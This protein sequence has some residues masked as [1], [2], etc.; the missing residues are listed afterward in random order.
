[1][2]AFVHR[3]PPFDRI[4]FGPVLFAA[5]IAA[6]VLPPLAANAAYVLYYHVFGSW[7]VV[8]SMDE[9]SKR[10]WCSLSAPPPA[11]E[12]AGNNSLITVSED[13]SGGMTVS[14][15]LAGAIAPDQPAFIRIDGKLQYRVQ[16]NRVGE[17]SWSGAEAAAIVE[18]FKRG[19]AITLRSFSAWTGAPRDEALSLNKF[20]EALSTYRENRRIYGVGPGG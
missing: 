9:A 11:M 13:S 4:F 14:L 15:R 12:T 19:K 18:E 6:V 2:R 10:R 5:L 20:D 17:A 7:A 3:F 1:M 8:C 16:P